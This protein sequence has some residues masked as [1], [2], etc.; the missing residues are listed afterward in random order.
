MYLATRRRDS[1]RLSQALVQQPINGMLVLYEE[2]Y[3]GVFSVHFS[4]GFA[5]H[6]DGSKPQRLPLP[7][8]PGRPARPRLLAPRL[9]IDLIVSEDWT[10]ERPF[11]RASLGSYG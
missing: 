7:P 5:G 2:I 9:V 3:K 11:W 1:H 6:A 8:A 10:K 4:L